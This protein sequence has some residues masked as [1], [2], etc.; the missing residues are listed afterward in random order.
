MVETEDMTNGAVDAL[1]EIE[2]LPAERRKR[3]ERMAAR[4]KRDEEAYRLHELA[5]KKEAEGASPD[6]MLSSLNSYVRRRGGRLKL[7]AD[8]PDVGSVEL[9][10]TARGRIKQSV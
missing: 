5:S 10:L 8:L 7:V 2:R 1:E 6:L 4:M 9:Q 3:I